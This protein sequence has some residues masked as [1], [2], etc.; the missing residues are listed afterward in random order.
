MVFRRFF[1]TLGWL[2][3]GLRVFVCVGVFGV[4]FDNC[5][6]LVGRRFGVW[7][8]HVWLLFWFGSLVCVI[9]CVCGLLF[10]SVEHLL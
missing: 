6:G 10:N 8:G 9:G 3:C 7:C 2:V 4:G 1:A 5:W